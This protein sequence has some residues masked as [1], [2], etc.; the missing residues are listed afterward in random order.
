MNRPNT[1]SLVLYYISG[2]LAI[3]FG[4]TLFAQIIWAE[5]PPMILLEGIMVPEV[6]IAMIGSALLHSAAWLRL[7]LDRRQQRDECHIKAF[8]KQASYPK[9]RSRIAPP[10]SREF[11]FPDFLTENSSRSSREAQ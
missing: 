10:Q 5:R 3:A 7:E 11:Q 4:L 6:L 8:L 9:P 2:I 1:A